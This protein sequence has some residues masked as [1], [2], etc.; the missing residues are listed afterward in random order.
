VCEFADEVTRA[1]IDEEIL[2]YIQAEPRTFEGLYIHI[3]T[4]D[5]D[6]PGEFLWIVGYRIESSYVQLS[7][8]DLW[9]ERGGRQF[10]VAESASEYFRLV[11]GKSHR[12][13]YIYYPD[14]LLADYDPPEWCICVDGDKWTAVFFPYPPFADAEFLKSTRKGVY[15]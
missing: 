1:I 3:Y 8:G 9:F 13:D 5:D 4:H 11:P 2:P 14:M 15:D 7:S 10:V 12:F 6:P